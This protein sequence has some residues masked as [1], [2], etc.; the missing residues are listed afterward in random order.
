MASRFTR[1][2]WVALAAGA[3]L[4]AAACGGNGAGAS[5]D[6]K[7]TVE[8]WGAAVGLDKSVDL[9]NKSHSD[10][11]IKYSQIAPG[12][13]GGYAKMLS[14]VK[15]GNAPCLGQVGYDTMTNF[16]ASGALMDVA[17]YADSSKDQ[18]VP[19]AWKMSSFGDGVYGIPTDIGP[20]A[21]YYRTDLFKKFGITP[22]TTWDEF[23]A[24]A[25]K[26]H[27]AS[28]KSYLASMPQDAYDLGALTWQTGGSWFGTTGDKWQVRIDSPETQKVAQY[29]QGLLGKGLVS[30]APPFDTTW[31]KE[32]QSGHIATL[33]G[34]AWA[35]ALIKSN[36]PDLAGKWA[37]A[38]LPQWTAGG[39]AA[40]NRGGSAVAV[41]KGCKNP[42]EATQ[43]AV[44]INSNPASVTSLITNTGIYPAA[45]SG[46]DLPAA[47]QASDYF[48]GQNIFE[49][50]K[51]A[52]ANIDPNWVWGPTM[53]Q[54]QTDFKDE[55]KKV[56]A[57]QGTIPDVLTTLQDKTV[58][59]IKS[60]GL[61]VS[62]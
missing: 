15:A 22:P 24:A 59:A 33:V 17:K 61:D 18:F 19:W 30:T 42:K 57:G 12:S 25:Q 4:T 32:A 43:A 47:N 45:K 26:L 20:M 29:W 36:L 56:G 1:A 13:S 62:G 9:W 37:V 48:G 46:Q 23:A 14:A 52:A 49:V 50:F 8:F 11:Q 41:L 6:K 7:V 39:N 55:L 2:A 27:Q 38:P 54:V 21:L 44:W 40:G 58:A 3:L 35:S 28:P 31:F 51:T 5:A 10:V 34:A 60:Q 16:V 53:T